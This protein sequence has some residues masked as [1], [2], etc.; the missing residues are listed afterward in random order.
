MKIAIFEAEPWEQ[1]LFSRLDRE[2]EILFR[3]EP[4][5]IS[6]AAGFADVQIISTFIYSSLGEDVLRLLPSLELIATRSTGFDHIALGYCRDH[7]IKI[8][9]VPS[10]GSCTVAEHVFGLILTISRRLTEAI[11]RTRSGNFSLE[12]LKGFDLHGKV[13]GVIGT[14]NIGLCVIRIARGFDME[15]V[16]FDVKR[17]DDIARGMGFTYLDMSELLRRS[18][19]ITLH[20][21]ASEKTRNLISFDQFEIMKQGAIII[22]TSRGSLVNVEALLS[23]L[24]GGRV[25]AA[26]LDVL[27]EEPVIREEAELLRSIFQRRHNLEALLADQ[28]LLRM[29]NVYITPHSAFYTQEALLDILNTTVENIEAFVRGSPMNLVP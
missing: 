21:P 25:S 23:A 27:P 4:L 3:K 26:G 7:D 29:R 20:V 19:I 10:Y 12:G 24:A 14:G 13:L 22:N 11:D 6:N 2:N 8:S 17:R 1:D 9:N 18:D 15:V 5:S 16:A 28:V